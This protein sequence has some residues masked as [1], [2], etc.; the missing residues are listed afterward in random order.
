MRRNNRYPNA[1]WF[2]ETGSSK[3][4]RCYLKEEVGGY[5]IEL[6]MN[7]E[8]LEAHGI[9]TTT[10]FL[11]LPSIVIHQISFSHMDWTHLSRYVQRKF[12]HTEVILRK[13]RERKANL[14]ELLKFLRQL[15]VSNPDR[16]LIPMA[17]NGQISQALKRWAE[18][19]NRDGKK[20][21]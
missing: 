13:A 6:Q 18:Q 7:R 3:F 11:R 12:R 4:L 1:V 21:G 8:F 20:N 2:G 17:I 19:W 10:D 5:R 16:F 9:R 14:S 15:G